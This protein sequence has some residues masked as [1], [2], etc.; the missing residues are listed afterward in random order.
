MYYYMAG[1]RAIAWLL[2][3]YVWCVTEQSWGLYTCMETGQLFHTSIRL[4]SS[5]E[6]RQQHVFKV[7]ITSPITESRILD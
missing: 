7:P 5:I 6:L 3:F 2:C 1:P 4:T